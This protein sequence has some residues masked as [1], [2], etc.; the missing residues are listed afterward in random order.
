MSERKNNKFLGKKRENETRKT[1]KK[2]KRKNEETNESF[3]IDINERNEEEKNDDKNMDEYEEEEGEG[4]G[5]D[6]RKNDTRKEKRKNSINENIRNLF[7][8]RIKKM[9]VK[10]K[11]LL[12][13]TFTYIFVISWIITVASGLLEAKVRLRYVVLMVTMLFF[14]RM[15]D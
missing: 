2:Q 11:E 14:L 4:E 12:K 15:C 7:E 13:K 3:I 5:E 8:V 9:R 10:A 1:P 6:F